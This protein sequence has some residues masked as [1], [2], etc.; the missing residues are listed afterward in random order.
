MARLVGGDYGICT[1][2]RVL[3]NT[4]LE[5]LRRCKSGLIEVCLKGETNQRKKYSVA[6]SALRLS[7]EELRIIS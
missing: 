3:Y 1:E 4:D 7:P 2:M 5:V 6:K